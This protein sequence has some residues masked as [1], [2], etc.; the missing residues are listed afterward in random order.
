[1]KGTF[2]C[3]HLINMADYNKLKDI[4]VIKISMSP[5]PL[6]DGEFEGEYILC[7]GVKDKYIVALPERLFLDVKAN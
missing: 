7:E 4:H 5:T 1:M 3:S 2:R 6:F